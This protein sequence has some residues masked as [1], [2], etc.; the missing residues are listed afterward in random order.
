MRPARSPYR[1]P[2]R[3]SHLH[4]GPHHN[5]GHPIRARKMAV[6]EYAHPTLKPTPP[7]LSHRPV[8]RA[9]IRSSPCQIQ[10]AAGVS[11]GFHV[12]MPAQG[13]TERRLVRPAN[14][15]AGGRDIPIARRAH[16]QQGNPPGQGAIG[17]RTCAAIRRR[18][19]RR[20]RRATRRG[21]R[22]TGGGASAI[23]ERQSEALANSPRVTTKAIPASDPRRAKHARPW[24]N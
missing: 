1:A 24:D 17:P 10:S 6:P 2:P 8:R 18:G 21:A 16:G 13:E 5:V 19:E 15:S 9:T 23:V 22:Q 3:A 11:P 20:G 12:K 4:R 14:T 7:R